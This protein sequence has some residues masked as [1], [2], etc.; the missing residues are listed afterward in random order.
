MCRSPEC[1]SLGISNLTF[2]GYS[3][4]WD[5]NDSVGL[6]CGVWILIE[7]EQSCPLQARGCELVNINPWFQTCIRFVVGDGISLELAAPCLFQVVPRRFR[8]GKVCE[9]STLQSS[10]GSETSGVPWAPN[11]ASTGG[12]P[13]YPEDAGGR[14]VQRRHTPWTSRQEHF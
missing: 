4:T 14:A 13:P 11:T 7:I 5:G 9:R 6:S 12:I 3:W 10:V 1:G 2:F 8:W